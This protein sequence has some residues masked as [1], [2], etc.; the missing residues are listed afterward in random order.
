MARITGMVWKI[1]DLNTSQFDAEPGCQMRLIDPS[2][3]EHLSGVS[4]LRRTDSTC[5]DCGDNRRMNMKIQCAPYLPGAYRIDLISSWDGA[6]QAAEVDFT[7]S[8]E[9][10]Q[11]VH[12]VFFPSE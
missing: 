4:G 6:Q 7:V 10:Q 3:Q 8:S 1:I 12:V 5:P 2:G 9:P 11:Y